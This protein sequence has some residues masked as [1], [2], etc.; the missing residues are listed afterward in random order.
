MYENPVNT[1]HLVGRI[2]WDIKLD[3]VGTL[4]KTTLRMGVRRAYKDKTTQK[5]ETDWINVVAL[6]ESAVTVKNLL[7]KGDL[8]AVT[9]SIRVSQY[10][11][12][13]GKDRES[14][15]HQL[16]SFSKLASGAAAAAL[17]A[18]SGLAEGV[19]LSSDNLPPAP[20]APVSSAPE[21]EIPF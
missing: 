4:D 11:S 19:K 14:V 16:V 9:Y 13:E 6:G 2:G 12:K 7:N 8:V 21:Q 15:E 1:G 18:P 5:Y 3:K 17:A 10:K 20:P